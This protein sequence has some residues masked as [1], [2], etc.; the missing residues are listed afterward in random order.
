MRYLVL[1]LLCLWAQQASA[2]DFLQRSFVLGELR[3]SALR[4]KN[5]SWPFVTQLE[6]KKEW[7]M[8]SSNSGMIAFSTPQRATSAYDPSIS[9]DLTDLYTSKRARA[10]LVVNQFIPDTNWMLSAGYDSGSAAPKIVVSPT[11]FAGV[12]GYKK[13]DTRLHFYWT[14]GA[15]QQQKI[16]EYPCIDDYDREYW[17]PALIAWSDRPANS[18]K[19][20]RFVNFKLEYI[21]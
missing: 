17:C 14:S 4:G 20:G 18:F 13:L 8:F 9:Y 19:P 10:R 7:G 3:K 16:T 12:S 1:M 15:W 6:V 2:D 5:F 11:F 21:F